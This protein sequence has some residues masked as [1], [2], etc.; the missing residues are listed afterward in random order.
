MQA[1]HL[2]L[3]LKLFTTH[4]YPDVIVSGNKSVLTSLEFVLFVKRYCMR[5][6]RSVPNVYV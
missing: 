5:L 2:Q 3:I 6:I 4:G 1:V